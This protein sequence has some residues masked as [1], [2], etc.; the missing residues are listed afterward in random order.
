MIKEWMII[1]LSLQ[2][3]NSLFITRKGRNWCK[4]AWERQGDEDR[5]WTALLTHIVLATLCYI[6]GPTKHF[7]CLKALLRYGLLPLALSGLSLAV[8]LVTLCLT[9]GSD[10]DSLTNHLTWVPEYIKFPNAYAFRLSTNVNPPSAV[11]PCKKL[12]PTHHYLPVYTA[13]T[14]Q[15]CQRSICNTTTP[16]Q[17]GTGINR[18]KV[19]YIPEKLTTGCRLVS[20]TGHLF[21][22][23]S[24]QYAVNII[25]VI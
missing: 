7:F 13:G 12:T 3:Y 16:I 21:L 1:A 2:K 17:K 8:T 18:N 5:R 11:N 22:K 15:L 24:Q 25:D 10:R 19:L 4:Y 20:Y 14:W 6:Q 9:V 23:E